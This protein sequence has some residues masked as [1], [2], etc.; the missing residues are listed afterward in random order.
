M[1]KLEKENFNMKM[2]LFHL[3]EKLS[4]FQNDGLDGNE[5][6]NNDVNELSADNMSLRIRLEEAGIELEQRNKLLIKVRM[7]SE[8]YDFSV[9]L[10]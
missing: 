1:K 4:Q 3:E 8:C 6:Y 5:V 7:M 9:V 10:F 2:K